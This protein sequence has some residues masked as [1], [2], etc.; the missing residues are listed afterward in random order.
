[1]YCTILKIE[2]YVSKYPIFKISE[3]ADGVYNSN[4][5]KMIGKRIG[6]TDI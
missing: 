6:G 1:M 2:E 3:K 4:D 5:S